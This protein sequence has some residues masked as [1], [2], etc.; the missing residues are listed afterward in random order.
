M[1]VQLMEIMEMGIYVVIVINLSIT[2]YE[3]V[4]W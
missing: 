2:V 4:K 3:D 1:Y